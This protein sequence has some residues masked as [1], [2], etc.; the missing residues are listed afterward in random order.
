MQDLVFKNRL[1]TISKQAKHISAH[2]YLT[3]E[4][5]TSSRTS[6]GTIDIPALQKL[7]IDVKNGVYYVCGP[8]GMIQDLQQKLEK[9]GVPKECI[10][11]E[12]WL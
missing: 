5:P 1:D 10:I 9:E 6:H 7:G 4:K 8:L 3:N 11:T 12:S 2:Y